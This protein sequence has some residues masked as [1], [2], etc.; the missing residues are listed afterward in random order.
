[1]N[2]KEDYKGRL[3]ERRYIEKCEFKCQD[4]ERLSFKLV[5]C[6]VTKVYMCFLKPC[7]LVEN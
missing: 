6:N 7:Y 3:F 2:G 1:M 4:F 5:S